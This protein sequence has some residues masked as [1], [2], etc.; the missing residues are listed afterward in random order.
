MPRISSI[1]DLIPLRETGTANH[2]YAFPGPGGL[3]CHPAHSVVIGMGASRELV[4]CGRGSHAR[5]NTTCTQHSSDDLPNDKDAGYDLEGL[6]PHS[7]GVGTG[8][9]RKRAA[10]VPHCG[11]RWTPLL[12]ANEKEEETLP[13]HEGIQPLL[14]HYHNL[15]KQWSRGA[16]YPKAH[17]LDC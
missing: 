10:L 15:E 5:Q 11:D 8:H 13:T 3:T 4:H 16:W 17:L 9:S 12:P 1:P 6:S 2:G 14:Q 7:V